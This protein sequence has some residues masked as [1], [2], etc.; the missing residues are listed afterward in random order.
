MKLRAL[1]AAVAAAALAASAATAAPPP[2]KGKPPTTGVGCKPSVAVILTGTLKADATAAPSALSVDVTGG[3]RFA[4]AYKKLTQPTALISITATTRISRQ[5]HH[6]AT[7]LKANDR[8]NIMARACKAD[9]A[10]GATPA[11]T[12]K[13]VTAQPA[14]G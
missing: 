5:G 9:L 13:R 10:N 7:D 4:Q 1:V 6:N 11:L 14:S 3:N 2:G 8:V 12:A